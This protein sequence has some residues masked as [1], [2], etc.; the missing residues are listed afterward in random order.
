MN[1]LCFEKPKL[2]ESSQLLEANTL[3]HQCVHEVSLAMQT[4]VAKEADL[5]IPRDARLS[6]ALLVGLLW[7][8]STLC[9]T[10]PLPA[11]TFTA[12]VFEPYTD[13]YGL[14]YSQPV[15]PPP[16]PF[17]AG[18]ANDNGLLYTAEACVIMQ[19]RNV[20][21]NRTQIAAG[22]KAA[23]VV[24]GL[25]NHSP[26]NHKDTEAQDDYIGLGA[27]AGVCGFH[28]VA[29]DILNYGTGGAQASGPAALLLDGGNFTSLSNEIKQCKTVPYNYNNIAPGVFSWTTWMG[30]YPAMITHWKLGA[31]DRPTPSEFGVWSAELIYSGKENKPDQDHWLQSW[32]MV[33]TY[34]MSQYHSTVADFAVDQ[35]WKMLHARYPG[36][37]KQT[38]TDYL[39][40]GAPGNPLAEYIDDFQQ[41]RNPSAV[42]VDA[43][44]SPENLLGSVQGLL[45]M[46]C[47]ETVQGGACVDYKDFSPTNLL[48]PFT[49]AL[50]ASTNAV[51]GA[52]KALA[53]QQQAFDLQSAAVNAAT[54]VSAN[55]NN[56]FLELQ[57]QHTALQQRAASLALQKAS[58]IAKG[59]DKLPLPGHF[60]T[61]PCIKAFGHCVTPAPPVFVPGGT[62]S[63]PDF[64]ALVGSAADAVN[65][66]NAVQN[67][68]VQVQQQL[69]TAQQDLVN[70]TASMNAMK[71]VLAQ[72]QTDLTKAKGALVLATGALEYIQALA[73]NLNP[74]LGDLPAPPHI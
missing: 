35:W 27:L 48:A 62:K 37:I 29:R 42:I 53:I 17:I 12:S 67:T 25:Y 3:L 63:N 46:S 26:V 7:I 54:Q 22:V 40:A 11:Q 21:Y 58:M 16:P 36:G 47:G 4:P 45:T 41:A 68:I 64:E 24:P 18:P 73:Q 70:K 34:E 65:Q 19:L 10:S 38:M 1:Q 57:T 56:N 74:C 9:A 61:P 52:S 55:L 2:K 39:A 30:K 49:T 72:L 14:I 33:L 69:S 6:S 32:L 28:D 13:K 43:D 50:T 20:P 60:V 23:Q 15:N 44:D 8:V 59:L 31:G 66:A 51:D 5:F 71:P